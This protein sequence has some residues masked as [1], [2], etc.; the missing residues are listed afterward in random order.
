MLPDK[1]EYLNSFDIFYKMLV[2][3]VKEDKISEIEFYMLLTAKCK[4]KSKTV[5]YQKRA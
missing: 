2:N 5:H 3:Q 1:L 4:A